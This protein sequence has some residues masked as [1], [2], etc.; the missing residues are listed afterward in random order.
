MYYL[1]NNNTIVGRA[2]TFDEAVAN[3]YRIEGASSITLDVTFNEIS[4]NKLELVNYGGRWKLGDL[5]LSDLFPTMTILENRKPTTVH[6]PV[7]TSTPPPTPRFFNQ[8]PN[9]VPVARQQP[10]RNIYKEALA[11]EESDD[12]DAI[13]AAKEAEEKRKK[14]IEEEERVYQNY[15][16]NAR[17]LAARDVHKR[18]NAE[19][20]GGYS[21]IIDVSNQINFDI[22]DI[23]ISR[24]L[25][26]DDPANVDKERE[27]FEE[28]RAEYTRDSDSDSENS[29]DAFFQ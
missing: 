8:R 16:L 4:I 14:E 28:L 3:L 20:G 24:G 12:E 27:L 9:I 7:V 11:Q 2:R 10:K 23:M 18:I 22:I 26:S 13:N 5:F 21:D 19:G 25:I 6:V 15:Q 1:L 29:V 17:Y